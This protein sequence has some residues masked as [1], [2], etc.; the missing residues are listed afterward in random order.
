MNDFIR[1]LTLCVSVIDCGELSPPV[2][3]FIKYKESV[4]ESIATYS[5]KQGY[6]L[7]GD[8]MRLCDGSGLWSGSTPVCEGTTTLHGHN[9]FIRI[10]LFFNFRIFAILSFQL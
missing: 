4:F 8:V 1:F 3:G 2:N 6:D 10:F 7:V 9:T 5:C